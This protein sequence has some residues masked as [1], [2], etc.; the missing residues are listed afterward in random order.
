MAIKDTSWAYILPEPGPPNLF[1]RV[2]F[3][4]TIDLRSCT[5]HYI[6]RETILGF[7]RVV[8]LKIIHPNFRSTQAKG[9]VPFPEN[10]KHAPAVSL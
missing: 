6:S 5:A 8:T 3:L 4:Q 2:R 9:L 7:P 10:D 1:L